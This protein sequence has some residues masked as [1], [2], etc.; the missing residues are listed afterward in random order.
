MTDVH[1][2]PSPVASESESK[3]TTT[4]KVEA[5]ASEANITATE[6]TAAPANPDTDVAHD[7]GE[8]RKRS[9]TPYSQRIGELTREKYEMKA[10]IAE[11]EARDAGAPSPNHEPADPRSGAPNLDA[12]NSY[13]EWVEATA[14]YRA[15]K[16]FNELQKQSEERAAQ[17]TER[18]AQDQRRTAYTQRV[19]NIEDRYPDY[20]DVTAEVPVTRAMADFMLGHDKG[21]DIAYYLGKNPDEAMRITKL[22]P[23]Q[24]GY[25]LAR[26]EATMTTPA[27]MARMTTK[28][29]EPINP[30]RPRDRAPTGNLNTMPMGE[31]A[32]MR[33]QQLRDA[34][35]R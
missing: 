29:P 22:S 30:V 23:V 3:D 10:R 6:A 13:E 26:L 16:R 17:E 9:G 24:Q 12:F 21:P 2:N 1:A 27:S 34:R 4:V 33:N 5:R 14:D 7:A 35:K 11:L 32:K 19:E 25:E 18:K 15:E 20:H 28:A 8:T 31:Y